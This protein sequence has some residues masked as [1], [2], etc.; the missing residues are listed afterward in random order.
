MAEPQDPTFYERADD[1]INLANRQAESVPGPRVAASL[2][3]ATARFNAWL[4]ANMYG[5]A[6]EMQRQRDD[7]IARLTEHYNQMLKDSFDDF[8]RD[9]QGKY[10]KVGTQ[11][12]TPGA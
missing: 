3:F 12:R 11:T 5:S 7:A 4:C 10:F 2:S 8:I 9:S 1:H 6:A